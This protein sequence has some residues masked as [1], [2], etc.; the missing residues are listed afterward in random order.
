M[1][2]Q[3]TGSAKSLFT[4]EFVLQLAT[5]V[6]ALVVLGGAVWVWF[7]GYKETAEALSYGRRLLIPLDGGTIEGKQLSV[8][9]LNKKEKPVAAATE[10]KPAG[11][12]QAA[13]AESGS[14]GDQPATVQISSAD[15]GDESTAAPAVTPSQDPLPAA[16][17]ELLEKA[18]QGSLPVIGKDGT[19][20]WRYYSKPV[21][22]KGSQPM[23]AIVVTGLGL[24]KEVTQ[25][26]LTLPE[27]IS[28]SFSPYGKDLASW[29]NAARITGHEALLDLPMEPS[30]YPAADPG[31]QGLLLG[32]GP[33]ENE[34]RLRWFM[35]RHQ[36]YVGFATPFNESFLDDKEAFGALLQSIA[37]RGLMLLVSRSPT[38]GEIQS[39]VESSNTAN[40]VADA[41]IDEEL[42]AATINAH[43]EALEQLAKKRG[44][45]VGMARAYPLTLEQLHDWSMMLAE[46]GVM[47]VPVS[48]VAK[49]RFS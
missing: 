40:V 47:L 45:A 41:I 19:K 10:T 30:N 46:R 21:E 1:A 43:L 32:K 11:E 24:S 31:P 16:N 23:V 36:G 39:L 18:D 14:P 26:A 2:R 20:P 13:A 49:L 25:N 17:P 4:R 15:V 12:S 37:N 44:Y 27:V 8:D 6:L 7:S 5:I 22:R 3:S 28:L 9:D 34:Q 33:T 48:F 35:A 29:A 42:S 38:K